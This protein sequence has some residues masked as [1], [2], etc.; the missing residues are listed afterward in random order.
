MHQPEPI[1]QRGGQRPG[2]GRGSDQGKPRQFEFYGPRRST[3][4]DHQ[5]KLVILHRRIER[6]FHRRRQSVNL[7][8]EQDIAF[9]QIGQNRGQIPGVAQDQPGRRADG[10]SHF[11]RDDVCNGG[12]TQAWWAVK[13]RMVQGLTTALGRF[14]ANFQRFLHPGLP[15]ILPQTLRAQRCLEPA[16]VVGQLSAHGTVRHGNPLEETGLDYL[17][18]GAGLNFGGGGDAPCPGAA[19]LPQSGGHRTPPWLGSGILAPICCDWHCDTSPPSTEPQREGTF[20][21]PTSL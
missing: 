5:I 14:D 18:S 1:S 13:N 20:D 16:L 9:L 15:D 7:I 17:D 11:P 4:S 3:L 10:R 21:R 6:L 19:M 12:L 2:S 8:D